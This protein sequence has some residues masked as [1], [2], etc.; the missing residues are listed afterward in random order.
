MRKRDK[1]RIN[2][3][4]QH[5]HSPVHC[6]LCCLE[7]GGA[8]ADAGHYRLRRRGGVV[9]N[10]RSALYYAHTGCVLFFFRLHLLSVGGGQT[11][12]EYGHEGLRKIFHNDQDP[13]AE[14]VGVSRAV[15][16]RRKWNSKGPTE[17]STAQSKRFVSQ[18]VSRS[19]SEPAS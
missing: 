18:S 12:D 15:G 4:Q 1:Q 5:S 19:A 3:D 16:R 9:T 17:K 7:S 8:G 13:S 6:E 11:G 2:A 14:R 10:N